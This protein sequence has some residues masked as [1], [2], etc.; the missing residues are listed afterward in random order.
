MAGKS[1]ADFY[2]HKNVRNFF[3][4]QMSQYT[5]IVQIKFQFLLLVLGK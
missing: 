5:K 1:F 2:I 3:C 4:T